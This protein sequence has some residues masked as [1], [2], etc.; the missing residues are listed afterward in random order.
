MLL[1][2]AIDKLMASFATDLS[3]VMPI[4]SDFVVRLIRQWTGHSNRNAPK[5]R[6]TP[7]SVLMCH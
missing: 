6:H 3:T 5:S 2:S 7:A 1:M 4:D